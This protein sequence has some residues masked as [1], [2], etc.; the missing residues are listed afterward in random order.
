MRHGESPPMPRN[1]RDS[2][3]GDLG[4]ETQKI[5]TS[6]HFRWLH[7]IVQA[8]LVLNVLD[9]I[10]TIAEIASGRAS[11]ANPLMAGLVQSEPVCFAFVKIL[12]VSLGSYLLWQRR[13]RASAVCAI[14]VAF[15]AYYFLLLYHLSAMDL[16]LLWRLFD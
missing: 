7:G 12:L 13:Q 14:F 10:L 6:E 2:C 15:L 11:E 3:G 16:R 1:R 4:S 9:A 5:G 8:L